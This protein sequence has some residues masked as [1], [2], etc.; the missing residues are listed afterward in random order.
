MTARKGLLVYKNLRAEEYK[1]GQPVFKGRIAVDRGS[2]VLEFPKPSQ[3]GR[4]AKEEGVK[5]EHV[6]RAFGHMRGLKANPGRGGGALRKA[7]KIRKG[8]ISIA[9]E[10]GHQ[11]DWVFQAIPPGVP[12]DEVIPGSRP[13][14]VIMV[15]RG[16]AFDDGGV[17][18]HLVDVG[19]AMKQARSQGITASGFQRAFGHIK[20]LGTPGAKM[21]PSVVD[22]FGPRRMKLG[23]FDPATGEV[24]GGVR[25]GSLVLV[26]KRTGRTPWVAQVIAKA[27]RHKMKDGSEKA[28]LIRFGGGKPHDLTFMQALTG[29]GLRGPARKELSADARNIP[30]LAF[31]N[32]FAYLLPKAQARALYAEASA[33]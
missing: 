24:K 4:I 18:A 11:D 16:G 12:S 21:P 28:I 32:A 19:Q 23:H 10:D 31:L 2:G 22:Y 5:A 3:F 27:D 14:Q 20:K 9:D 15:T 33:R 29:I 26:D 13:D 17:G 7:R 8:F 25:K 1:G 30:P 6:K